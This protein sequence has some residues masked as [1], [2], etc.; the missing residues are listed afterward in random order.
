MNGHCRREPQDRP[1]SKH[2]I[3]GCAPWILLKTR[4]GRRFVHNT[5][6]KESLW[7]FPQ[8]VVGGVVEYDIQERKRKERGED[9][10]KVP[11][12][13]PK[14]EEAP[15][16]QSVRPSGTGEAEDGKV[17]SD[18][19][20]AAGEPQPQK[21]EDIEEI[22]EIE[23][24][25][26]EE[27]FPD[28]NPTKRQRTEGSQDGEAQ[29]YEFGEDDMAYQLAQ[30]EGMQDQEMDDYAGEEEGTWDDAEEDQGALEDESRAAFKDLLDDLSISP[31][32]TW[33]SVIDAGRIVEDYRYTLLPNT[34]SRKEVFVEWSADRIQKVKAE[35]EKQ[36][37]QDPR[38][39]YLAL[40]QK[41]ATPKLYW[42]EFKRKYKKEPEMKDLKLSD[43]E[44]EKLYRDHINRTTKSSEP[45]LKA[46][47]RDLLKSIPASTAWHRDSSLDGPLPPALQADVRYIS[48]KP[49]VR[50]SVVA[51]FIRT[52]PEPDEALDE[53]QR[54]E[55][56]R[57]KAERSKQE[58]ALRERQRMVD[59]ARRKRRR[60]LDEGRDALDREAQELHRAMRV[61]REGLVAHLDGVKRPS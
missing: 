24:T 50:D 32:T 33:E 14:P 37:R 20:T 3:P 61:G 34:K 19:A 40:L 39:P 21:D 1:K 12:A 13:Q 36:A 47:L 25:D 54:E 16:G 5:E 46:D 8:H 55:L 42:P 27:E 4:L 41:H 26:D 38:I 45:A 52:L 49:K 18:I 53:H 31:F 28:D 59:E 15:V 22:E 51:D 7:K 58:K 56:A 11:A 10:Q 43:K 60:D 29:Q 9:E 23:V 48:L 2:E 44:R 6:T 17:V 30:M 57:K 35:K